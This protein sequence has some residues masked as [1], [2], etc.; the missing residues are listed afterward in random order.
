M[1]LQVIRNTIQDLE[2][3]DNTFDNCAKLASLYIICNEAEKWKIDT[4]STTTESELK[5]ILPAY[6]QYIQ[7]K[8][9]Y[10]LNGTSED[11]TSKYMGFLCKEIYEF[12]VSLYSSTDT[13]DERNHIRNLISNLSETTEIR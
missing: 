9:N 4:K 1:D 13:P 7:A 5:D 3:A 11:Q 6:K 10:Q 12:V 2:N 8:R